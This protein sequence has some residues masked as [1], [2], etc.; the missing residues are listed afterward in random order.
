MLLL[1]KSCMAFIITAPFSDEQ[2]KSIN[3]YQRDGRFP[4]MVCDCGGKIYG[5]NDGLAC[6]S[7]Y[8][9][10]PDCPMFVTN[11]AWRSFKKSKET[12]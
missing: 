2:Q 5:R 8:K 4:P 9:V 10:E 1:Y 3:T 11:W 6:N 12:E 7:C